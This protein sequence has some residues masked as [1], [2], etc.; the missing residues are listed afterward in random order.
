[1]YNGPWLRAGVSHYMASLNASL[2]RTKI[3][4]GTGNLFWPISPDPVCVH[5]TINSYSASRDN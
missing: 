5:G 1:M 4:E 2:I 3:S